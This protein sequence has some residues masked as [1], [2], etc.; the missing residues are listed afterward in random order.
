[1]DDWIFAVNCGRM[2]EKGGAPRGEIDRGQN[3]Y[4]NSSRKKATSD[5]P[6]ED[7]EP[8]PPPFNPNAAYAG[9]VDDECGAFPLGVAMNL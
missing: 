6:D 2:T 1:M 3:C 9:G 7:R 4:G 8:L 5:N